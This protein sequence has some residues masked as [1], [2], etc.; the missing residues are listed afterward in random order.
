MITG[1]HSI[2]Y[3]SDP[4]A[5]RSFF[6][7]VLEMP[8]VDVGDGWLIFALP[9]GELAVHPADRNNIHEIFLMCDDIQELRTKLSKQHV[10]CSNVEELSWG[11]LVRVTLPGGGNIGIYQP[12]HKRPASAS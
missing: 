6:R 4:L 8:H 11:S 2:I 10:P 3:S 1:A 12:R 9:P 5:D 7:D